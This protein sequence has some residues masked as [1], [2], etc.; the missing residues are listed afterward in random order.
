ME[1]HSS[2]IPLLVAVSAL[3]PARGDKV[4]AGQPVPDFELRTVLGG[5]GRTKLSEFRGQPVLI[6]WYST[7]F[8]GLDGAKLAADI[9]REINE[10]LPDSKLVVVLMEIKNHDASYLRALQLAEL[11]GARCWLLKNQEL[12]VTYDDTTGFPPKMILIG[13]DGTLLYAGSYQ[14]WNKA[15]KLLEAEIAKLEKGWGEDPLARKARALA[16]GQHKLGEARA[17]ARSSPRSPPSSTGASTRWCARSTTSPSRGSRR[18]WRAPSPRRRRR[19]TRT[20]PGPRARPE[21]WTST[22]RRIPSWPSSSSSAS[23]RS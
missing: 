7:V 19:W 16:W 6:V 14:S 12:P 10:D 15:K 18:A 1:F 20:S 5:D 11:P 13:V 2:L 8:A 4:A 23:T 3:S 22:G 21:P 17:R 9:D